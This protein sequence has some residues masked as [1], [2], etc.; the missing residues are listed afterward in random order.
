MMMVVIVEIVMMVKLGDCGPDD[1]HCGDNDDG[2]G[3]VGD[4]GS[5]AGD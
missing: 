4:S 5:S 1:V 3:S 2:V